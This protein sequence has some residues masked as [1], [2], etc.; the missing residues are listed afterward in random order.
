MPNSIQWGI[1]DYLENIKVNIIY[2]LQDMQQRIIYNLDCAI[3][4]LIA[5]LIFN[6]L[7]G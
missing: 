1:M 6:F 2:H 3:D 7:S 4:F 5:F